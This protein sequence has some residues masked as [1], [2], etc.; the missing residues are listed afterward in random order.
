[1]ESEGDEHPSP[2][3]DTVA[4][5]EI[6]NKTH[7][8]LVIA[9]PSARPGRRQAIRDTWL[10]WG[11]DRVVLRFFTER[12][13]TTETEEIAAL[14]AE[15]TTHGDVIQLDID[16]G[17]NF[18]L[19]LLESFRWMVE[20][21]VFDFFLRLD[22]DTFLC[23]RRLLDDLGSLRLGSSRYPSPFYSGS[24]VCNP[25]E[26]Y[27]DEAYILMSSEIIDRVLSTP[28]LR[29]SYTGSVTA[30][31]W[32]T[33]GRPG[34]RE[35]DVQWVRDSRLNYGGSWWHVEGQD[36]SL[37]CQHYISVHRTY[38]E[39]MYDAWALHPNASGPVGTF[40]YG[41]DGKCPY[42]AAGLPEERLEKYG[43]Q[44]CDSFTLPISKMYCGVEGC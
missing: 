26:S 5:Q 10:K 4:T 17:M 28:D 30:A 16:R 31:A 27:V 35:G 7:V 18:G 25:N 32:V 40:V 13:D 33:N 37:V 19:K 39:Q 1:M 41:D 29:C 44:P 43:T 34:N 20:R 24:M 2:E 22:D 12:P 21:Y 3:L 42:M 15:S 8:L 23:L 11:D 36:H 14:D 9:V 38:Q 6:V